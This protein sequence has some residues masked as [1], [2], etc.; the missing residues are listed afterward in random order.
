ML[1]GSPSDVNNKHGNADLVFVSKLSQYTVKLYDINKATG[2]IMGSINWPIGR[3]EM[4]TDALRVLRD[5]EQPL[6]GT[7]NKWVADSANY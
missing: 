7:S 2:A 1:W 3:N 5:N 6:G 4:L